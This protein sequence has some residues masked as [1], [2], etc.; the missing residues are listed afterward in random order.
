MVSMTA[1]MFTSVYNNQLT[2]TEI[3]QSEPN[4]NGDE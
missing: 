1:K 2:I 4:A 3:E